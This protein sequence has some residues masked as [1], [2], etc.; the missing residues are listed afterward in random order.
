MKKLVLTPQERYGQL[1]LRESVNQTGGANEQEV[2][3][4]EEKRQ[5]KLEVKT[6]A[7]TEDLT[8]LDS[9]EEKKVT[10]TI[11]PVRPPVNQICQNKRVV[12]QNRRQEKRRKTS[13]KV[14]GPRTNMLTAEKARYLKEIYFDPKQ[15]SSF[16]GLGK[17]YKFVKTQRGD[18][19]KGDIQTWLSK[20]SSYSLYRKV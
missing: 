2:K 1:L 9:E 18:I 11:P 20:Q 6:P 13:G 17:L 7:S 8:P 5:D 4:V 3:E 15:P 16:G 12:E 19:S 14:S 10:D